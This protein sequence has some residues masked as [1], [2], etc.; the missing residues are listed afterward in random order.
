MCRVS[1]CNEIK[2][3]LIYLEQLIS[4]PVCTPQLQS[5]LV[6]EICK[7]IDICKNEKVSLPSYLWDFLTHFEKINRR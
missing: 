3:H 6:A 2:L 7:Y 5:T 1:R 4:S